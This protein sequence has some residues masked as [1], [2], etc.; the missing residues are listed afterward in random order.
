MKWSLVGAV[1]ILAMAIIAT[2]GGEA[3]RPGSEGL[4]ALAND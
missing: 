3:A 1:A 4:L 2:P